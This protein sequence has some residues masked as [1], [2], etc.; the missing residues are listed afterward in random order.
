[1]IDLTWYGE[2]LMLS[3]QLNDFNIDA[4]YFDESEA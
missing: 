2:L 4:G 3:R 1:M